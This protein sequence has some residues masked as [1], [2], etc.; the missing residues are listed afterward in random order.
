MNPRLT[1]EQSLRQKSPMSKHNTLI[2]ILENIEFQ[3]VFVFYG[4]FYYTRLCIVCATLRKSNKFQNL[5][6]KTF[7]LSPVRSAICLNEFPRNDNKRNA[8]TAFYT[9]LCL[10]RKCLHHHVRSH[11]HKLGVFFTYVWNHTVP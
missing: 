1:H 11:L 5:K 6:E 2:P 3:C 9:F 8:I 7:P 10:R 4:Y